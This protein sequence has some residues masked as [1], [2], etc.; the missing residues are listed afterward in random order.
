MERWGLT[1][2]RASSGRPSAD[3]WGP[4]ALL[5]VGLG[6]ALTCTT[7]QE[8]NHRTGT[9]D[10]PELEHGKPATSQTLAKAEAAPAPQPSFSESES[11]SEPESESEAAVAPPP[12]KRAPPVVYQS[13][14]TTVVYDQPAWGS[15]IRGRIDPEH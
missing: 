3:V 5:I 7:G 2:G 11:E 6:V 14:R 10:T 13:K 9:P 1:P 12:V 4:R 15:P 8:R